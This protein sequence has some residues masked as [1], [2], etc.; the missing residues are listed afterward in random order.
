MF[1]RKCSEVKEK[2]DG[3]SEIKLRFFY[4]FSRQFV[5]LNMFCKEELK[6]WLELLVLYRKQTG[7]TPTL[8][9]KNSYFKSLGLLAHL[10]KIR[11]LQ[12]IR[13]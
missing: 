12:E 8:N 10:A 11:K 2:I 4:V 1:S 3:V 5:R 13:H 7:I 9:D 6:M